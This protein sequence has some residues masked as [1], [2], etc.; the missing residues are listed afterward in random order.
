MNF[1]P[2]QLQFTDSL[3]LC[4]HASHFPIGLRP[5]QGA[6]GDLYN[7]KLDPSLTLGCGSWGST[8][9]SSNVGPSN[10]LNIKSVTERREG[11]LWFRI[12]PKVYFKVRKQRGGRGS[13]R[14]GKEEE[15]KGEVRKVQP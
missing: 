15:R 8:S 1:D 3:A 2:L 7:T 10:L 11:M 6:I 4:Q 9:V 13:Y 14:G 5:P 12:P